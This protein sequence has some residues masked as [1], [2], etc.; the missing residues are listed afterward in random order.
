MFNGPTIIPIEL[1]PKDFLKSSSRAFDWCQ[2]WLNSNRCESVIVSWSLTSVFCETLKKWWK[3]VERWNIHGY[4]S[5]WVVSVWLAAGAF[6][7]GTR[8]RDSEGAS[9]AAWRSWGVGG[10][11]GGDKSLLTGVTDSSFMFQVNAASKWRV[12]PL[13]W[14]HAAI[15]SGNAVKKG[16]QWPLLWVGNKRWTKNDQISLPTNRHEFSLNGN[17][18]LTLSCIG[19]RS[20]S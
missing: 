14:P 17:A 1:N 18:V 10:W 4:R 11:V 20:L 15:G 9:A 13:R 2:S 16:R 6:G 5:E 3:V 19:G 7:S 12:S 8:Q